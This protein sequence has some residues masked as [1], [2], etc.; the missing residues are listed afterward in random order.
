MVL[1]FA[2]DALSTAPEVLTAVSAIPTARGYASPPVAVSAGLSALAASPQGGAL[3]TKRDGTRRT[4]AGTAAAIY[5]ISAGSWVDRSRGGGYSIGASRWAFGIM[6]D[7]SLAI[8]KSTVLQSST[9]GAFADV[10]N[11][12]KASTMCTA[13][14]FVVLGDCDDSGVAG[15]GTSYGDDPDR[16][17][18]SPFQDPTGDWDILDNGGQGTSLQL[19]ETDGAITRVERLGGDVV[20]YKAGSMYL[21]RFTDGVDVIRFQLV[22]DPVGC[23]SRDGL[24]AAAAGHFFI[25][26]DDFYFYDGT[27]PISIGLPIREWFFANVSRSSLST[28]QAMHDR[29]N[30]LV[31]WFYPTAGATLD[32]CV[33]Y[34][35]ATQRWGAFS[36]T[37]KDVLQAVTSSITI[38][39]LDAI[40]STI[41]GLPSIPFDSPYWSASTPVLAYFDS[42]NVLKQLSGTG[43]PMSV[44]TGWLGAEDQVSLCDRV[45]PKF[46][47]KPTSGTISGS[48]V[49]AIGD[50]PTSVA[51]GSLSSGRFDVLQAGR[52]HRFAMTFAD[53]TELEAIGPRLRLEGEE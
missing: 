50:T 49:M 27:R 43:G 3:L 39:G 15:L 6:G 29:A 42:S 31:Y 22:P 19:V 26:D 16:I 30:K 37:V 25:G 38:D 18:V 2:P 9:T 33:V 1:A 35:Y 12:P 44:T 21:G 20:A 4:L 47:T 24:V 45:R 36:L 13:Q 17:W 28:V 5:E 40:A 53:Q 32:S 11:A 51:S 46:R 14:G 52:Y 7:L 34:H 10:A 23:P 48:T 41:D 8:N